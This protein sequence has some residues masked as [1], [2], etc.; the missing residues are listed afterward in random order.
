MALSGKKVLVLCLAALM[1]GVLPLPSAAAQIDKTL[2]PQGLNHAGVFT[3]KQLDPNLT[4][5]GVKFA[6][7][8]RSITYIDDEPQNDYRPNIEHNCFKNKQITFNDRIL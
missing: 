7:I 8:S 4:G 1:V 2:Q 3:L 6:V 5:S